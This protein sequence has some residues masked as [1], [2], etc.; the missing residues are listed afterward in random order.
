[1]VPTERKSYESPRNQ[2]KQREEK[3]TLTTGNLFVVFFCHGEK[4]KKTRTSC[5]DWNDRRKTQQ[6]KTARW[7]NKVAKSN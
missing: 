6:K 7:T 3:L 1:M 5:D 2:T 4:R